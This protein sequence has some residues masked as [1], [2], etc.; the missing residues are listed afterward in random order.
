[1]EKFAHSGEFYSLLSALTFSVGVILFRRS[2]EL[3][4]SP[5]A[6]NTFK[7]TTGLALFLLTLLLV[8][9]PLLPNHVS[10]GDWLLL[11]LSGAIGIAL[12][13]SLFFMSLNRIGAGRSAIV[14]CL[15]SPV[16]ILSAFLFL[17]EPVG[18]ALL[19][20]MALMASAI[21]VGTWNPKRV[22]SRE[23]LKQM[24]AGV[25]IGIFAITT[26]AVGIVMAKPALNR[27]DPWW[28]A[29][30]RLVGGVAVLFVLL[31][32]RNVR[33]DVL[34]A[35]RPG[36]VWRVTLPAAF[37]GTYMAMAF[38]IRGM[39]LTHTSIASV[40]NQLSNIFILI[41]ATLIL[42]E[43]LTARKVA[44]IVMGVAAGII[45]VL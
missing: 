11:L 31:L 23:E 24:R 18:P 30:I 21:L 15:Y 22:E 28:S 12:A 43:H 40:L 19:I 4:V 25:I 3:A 35:F 20:A 10:T 2:G 32:K 44:A 42:R 45:A 29:T 1:M 8:G 27:T 41:L 26:M 37:I 17:G 9:H 16:I 6:L 38:W 36:P 39:T 5:I 13:D 33:Q 14:N 7:N 34:S